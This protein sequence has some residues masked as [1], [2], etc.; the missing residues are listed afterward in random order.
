MVKDNGTEDLF[1]QRGSFVSKQVVLV[2]SV[3]VIVCTQ[4]KLENVFV[5]IDTVIRHPK[6][7]PL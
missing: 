2:Q 5:V 6:R 7:T 1:S 3:I 4:Q